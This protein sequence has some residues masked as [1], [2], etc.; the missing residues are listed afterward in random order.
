MVCPDPIS[1][2]LKDT[3]G[4]TWSDLGQRPLRASAAEPLNVQPTFTIKSLRSHFK[5]PI[6][7]N[8]SRKIIWVAL[9][10]ACLG[11]GFN[12]STSQAAPL[13]PTPIAADNPLVQ[14]QYHHHHRRHHH[15]HRHR[16]HHHHIIPHVHVI[17]RFHHHHHHRY[18]H[19][20]RHHH[21][22]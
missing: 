18:H 15:H 16:R 9:L 17:P 11:L 20:R 3:R 14:V 7:G 5:N 10:G 4:H 22:H 19:H 2:S 13:S 8:M 12:I 6:G 21:H 1:S